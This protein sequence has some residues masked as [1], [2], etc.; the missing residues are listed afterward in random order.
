MVGGNETENT[1]VLAVSPL[2][3]GS[4]YQCFVLTENGDVAGAIRAAFP[5]REPHA[6]YIC[7]YCACIVNV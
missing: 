3:M 7:M 2:T 4:L 1:S 6:S 5:E